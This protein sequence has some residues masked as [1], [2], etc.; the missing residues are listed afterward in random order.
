MAVPDWPSTYGYN[1]F[2]YPWQTWLFGPWDLLIEHGHRLLGALVGFIAITFVWSVWRNDQRF[3]VRVAALAALGLVIIQG[4]LGGARVLFDERQLAMVHG[5]V[6]PAFFAYC[7]AL[8]VFT[9]GKWKPVEDDLAS[10]NL[11]RLQRISL[12]TVVF[13]YL[14][15]VIGAQL[16]HISVMAT[17]GFFRGAAL[18]H[19]V[20][21]AVVTIHVFQLLFLA[22]QQNASVAALRFPTTLL[23]ALVLIQLALGGATWVVKYGWPEFLA[24]HT[25]AAPYTIQAKSLFQSLIVTSHVATG[26]LIL[27]TSVMA[28]ARS[29]RLNRVPT[30]A[31]GSSALM[32][33][34]A[35]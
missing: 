18:F 3:G 7:I 20:M 32:M 9:S 30:V 31:L 33:E 13:A 11:P 28:F 26:S 19:L 5:C 4:G 6:G 21:A 12:L 29:V 10:A 17:P 35:T 2:A 16:R 23:A 14:Q 25:F 1:L 34:L 8:A 27:A 24:Q 15:L 22:K